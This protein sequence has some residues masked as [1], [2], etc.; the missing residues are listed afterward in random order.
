MSLYQKAGFEIVHENEDEYIMLCR[1]WYMLVFRIHF[2]KHKQ[3]EYRNNE[4]QIFYHSYDLL[5]WTSFFD[6]IFLLTTL[7]CSQRMWRWCASVWV[8]SWFSSVCYFWS[9]QVLI[10]KQLC[11]DWI[12]FSLMIGRFRLFLSAYCWC[13]RKKAH[14]IKGS[15]SEIP[16]GIFYYYRSLKIGSFLS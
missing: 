15:V 7:Y 10:L 6:R 2:M 4:D 14:P 8:C 5:V 9:S 3:H 1:L 11:L 13:G 16:A 12:I